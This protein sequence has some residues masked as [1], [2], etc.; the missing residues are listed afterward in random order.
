M[1]AR[2]AVVTRGEGESARKKLSGAGLLRGDLCIRSDDTH[3]FI[4]V[5]D[6][7][8]TG[9][10]ERDEEFEPAAA[11]IKSYKELADVPEALKELLPSSF[12]IIGDVAGRTCLIM[13]DMVD[14][15]NTLCEA[16]KALK[17]KGAERVLAYC[18]HGV[19]SGPA[20]ERI[21]KS[22]IDELVVTD[23]IP[24]QEN[25]RNCKRIRQ[26]SAAEL[27]AETMRRI[28]AEESV[29]SLFMD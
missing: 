1:R 15:A 27:L 12:D 18:T 21:E 17:E 28:N 16:A 20:I 6:G 11:R 14:T 24:L 13:D 9:Y 4:P 10:E 19:L 5:L 26:L 25:A 23:T 8:P 3:V 29:S 2:C 7:P 22:A